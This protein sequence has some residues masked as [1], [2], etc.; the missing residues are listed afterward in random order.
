MAAEPQ[1]S[2]MIA[3]L[4]KDQ[5]TARVGPNPDMCPGGRV[6]SDWSAATKCWLVQWPLMP[7][8]LANHGCKFVAP[9][10]QITPI[11]GS[12]QNL[13]SWNVV[14]M[15]ACVFDSSSKRAEGPGR[16]AIKPAMHCTWGGRIY[17]KLVC[18]RGAV[19]CN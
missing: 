15:L 19:K 2:Y 10:D 16:S 12:D 1:R 7:T 5:P 18:H 11:I 9:N 13:K 4:A 14:G 6:R 17:R 8:N 3:A